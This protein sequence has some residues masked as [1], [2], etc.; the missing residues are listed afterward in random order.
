MIYLLP[1]IEWLTECCS[2]LH[3]Q[4]LFVN[5]HL[6]YK[7]I[8]F[9]KESTY[10]EWNWYYPSQYILQNTGHIHQRYEAK[11]GERHL[12]PILQL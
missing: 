10:Q 6:C 4:L 9:L 7:Y 2:P 11:N 5:L 1:G 12:Q 3:I 8:S